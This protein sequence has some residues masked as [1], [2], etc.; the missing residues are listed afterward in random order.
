LGGAADEI[1]T[2]VLHLMATCHSVRVI[3]GSRVGD[4]LDVKMLEFTEWY[5]DEGEDDV[6]GSAGNV[7]G[8]NEGVESIGFVPPT[9]RPRKER[10]DV[11]KLLEHNGVVSFFFPF[12]FFSSL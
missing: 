6:S 1:G 4:P 3:G 9:V 8:S 5:L 11:A 10:V 12:F 7:S 2:Q